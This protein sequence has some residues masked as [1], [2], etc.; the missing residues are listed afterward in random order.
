MNEQKSSQIIAVIALF[1][2]IVA[3]GVAM[4]AMMTA[5]WA[6]ERSIRLQEI[7]ESQDSTPTE[8]LL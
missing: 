3:G 4:A 1:V 6:E 2:A 5:S 8:R 7:I